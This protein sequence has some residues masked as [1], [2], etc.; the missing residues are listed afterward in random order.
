MVEL[1]DAL[2]SEGTWARLI[3]QLISIL[4]Q[5]LG[6][7]MGMALSGGLISV[8]ARQYSDL[9]GSA[10]VSFRP[11]EAQTAPPLVSARVLG[12]R[13][14]PDSASLTRGSGLPLF[15]H[16]PKNAGRYVEEELRHRR[17]PTGPNFGR[18]LP[19]LCSTA[20]I[21]PALFAVDG[22]LRLQGAYLDNFPKAI[23]G[24]SFLFAALKHPYERAVS[25]FLWVS[26]HINMIWGYRK[27]RDDMN[28]YVQDSIQNASMGDRECQLQKTLLGGFYRKH[29]EIRSRLTFCGRYMQDCHWV[30]QA[31][32]VFDQNRSRQVISVLLLADN[33]S[34]ELRAL[35]GGTY[36]TS[37]TRPM[38]TPAQWNMG[39]TT[40][41]WLCDLSNSSRDMLDRYYAED[42][43][44]FG[45]PKWRGQDGPCSSP[46][47]PRKRPAAPQKRR[48][49]RK[50]R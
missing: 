21:P 22:H 13:S 1:R 46:A 33:I 27:T 14:G 35:L 7:G 36:D 45:F 26:K 41:G 6:L 42:F 20:H 17:M 47:A 28:R 2:A 19:V 43:A 37:V 24:N 3:R 9:P 25:Q 32:Y 11:P 30:P 12:T 40:G 4:L 29:R 10:A 48:R 31:D 39:H 49:P 18:R 50:G 23:V 15:V 8:A 44:L 38:P 5:L 16:I 34:S